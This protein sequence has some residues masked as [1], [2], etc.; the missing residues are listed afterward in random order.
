M[1]S[2]QEQC[3]WLIDS[4]GVF[5]THDRVVRVDGEDAESWLNGQVTA[6]VRNLTAGQAVYALSVSLKGRVLTDLWVLRDAQGLA[7]SLPE[8]ALDATLAAYD[9]HIIMEDVEL[10][11]CDDLRVVAVQGPAAAQLMA[12]L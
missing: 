12:A 8:H 3:A 5:V 2:I 7:L 6:D 4:V 1:A 10:S 11:P 9:R